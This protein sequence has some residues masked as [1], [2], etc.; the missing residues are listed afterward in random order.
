MAD[1]IP[2]RVQHKRMTAAQWRASSV[3]LLAGEL[4][5]ESD[6]GFVKVGD[7]TNRFSALKYLTG[8][9]GD[10]GERGETGATG[11]T[12]PRG[13]TGDRGLQGPQGVPG[14]Q[15]P[16]GADGVM[17]FEDLTP[18]Q[19]AS[20]KGEK[21]DKGDPLRFTDLTQAQK[22]ELRGPQGPKGAD[23]V[24]RFEDLTPTQKASLKGEPGKDGA[25]GP[26]GPKGAD[27]ARGSMGLQ[28]PRGE[29]GDP[30]QNI[31]N[32]RTGQALKYWAGSKAD[33]DRI[34]SKDAN[35]I[36]DVWE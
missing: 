9:K 8:P 10:K 30:G 18:Q 29:K 19:K 3:I 25:Q 28:G 23:G 24:L 20:L 5:V 22:N 6:T 27:G 4:G 26:A 21:G 11:A 34:S 31:L 36:Y 17:R 15:G 2:I 12:G 7:G 33:Y 35:T 14:P 32:S 13:A 16:K 1:T